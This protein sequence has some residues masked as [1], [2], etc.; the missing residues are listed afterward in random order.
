MSFRSVDNSL[1]NSAAKKVY[2][3]VASDYELLEVVGHGA[4]ATVYR[5]KCVPFNEEVGIKCVD[6]EKCNTNLDDIRRETKTMSLI[7]HPNVVRA[8]C[9]FVV[10]HRLWV[11][12]PYMA[13][14]SCLSIMKAAFPD[15]FD[16][17]I[18]ASIL[19]E[20]LK[21]LEYLHSHGQIHRD[22]KAG[23]VLVDANGSVKLGDFGVTACLFDTGDRQ[24]ARITFVGTPCWM[25]PEVMEQLNGYDFKA[26]IWSLGITALEL[27]HGH[28]P[29]SKYPPTK[30][31]PPGLDYDRDKRFSKA[32]K[33]MVATCLVKN[34]AKRP[35]AEKL[36]K[37]AFF[38]ATKSPESIV[39]RLLEKV[40]TMSRNPDSLKHID[41]ARLREKIFPYQEK[42][43]KSQH[44]YNKEVS[45]WNFDVEDLKAQAALIHDADDA[46][47]LKEDELTKISSCDS[48]PDSKM[49][50]NRRVPNSQSAEVTSQNGA[51][52]PT[53]TLLKKAWTVPVKS[54]EQSGVPL[55]PVNGSLC[56]DE[57]LRL[58]VNEEIVECNPLR[59][60]AA[61]DPSIFTVSA[62]S[63]RSMNEL[64]SSPRPAS[65]GKDGLDRRKGAPV[66]TKGRFRIT[67]EEMD[68][69]EAEA[70]SE[71]ERDLL[72][73]V[74]EL[75]FRLSTLSDELQGMKLKNLQLEHQL[76]AIYNK[77][78][79]ERICR[80][81][82]EKGIFV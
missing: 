61:S 75:Q 65:G 82:A 35:T 14:G 32:F 37:H 25:A 47:M 62:V 11:V 5:A 31:A 50:L 52:L 48:S 70:S 39:R 13:G 66:Q 58:K 81:E 59:T 19:K 53:D 4:S 21:A 69:V 78:E 56:M 33:E 43:E 51:Q 26:D 55:T 20:S 64:S 74:V 10:D 41:A 60:R 77:E 73:Q 29:F 49:S 18:I 30:N 22:V 80:E 44:E 71:R 24:R 42:E 16:E 3:T 2:P 28:A 8:Y 63:H 76:N 6:L 1:A 17:S 40:P 45:S 27:A 54:F 46:L 34:P 15:G 67:S 38:K 12:M 57:D 23:N 9:S 68:L 36:L 72:L 7:D 79:E